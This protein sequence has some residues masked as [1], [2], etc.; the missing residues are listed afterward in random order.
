MT[1]DEAQLVEDSFATMGPVTI[2]M[3]T[4]F[5][6]NLFEMAPE[7]RAMF[8]RETLEQA[9]RFS[10]VLAYIV[11]NLRAPE[12]LLP[13]VRDLGRRHRDLGVAPES[14]APFKQALLK[15]LEEKM[16]SRWTPALEAAWSATYDMLADE[17]L[18]PDGDAG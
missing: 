10:Q 14:H 15:T 17:M 16:Q 3:G 4:A 7:L 1:R 12:R 8:A 6:D 13:L 5:Y 11:S 9:M 2:A 18:R